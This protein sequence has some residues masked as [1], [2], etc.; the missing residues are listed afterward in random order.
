MFLFHCSRFC[1]IIS[2]R[3]EGIWKSVLKFSLNTNENSEV[4]YFFTYTDKENNIG[5][6]KCFAINSREMQRDIQ[7]S[8]A[9]LADMAATDVTRGNWA[10]EMRCNEDV[11]WTEAT[12][13]ILKT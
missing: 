12:Q 5:N 8:R 1:I 7:S 4:F 13:H 2:R 10:P 6:V 9:T 11:L 3:Y